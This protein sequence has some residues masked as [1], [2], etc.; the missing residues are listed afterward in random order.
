MIRPP[1]SSTLFPHPPLSR[2]IVMSLKL[3]PLIFNAPA[4]PTL[5]A[6]EPFIVPPVQLN[7]PLTVSVA[8]PA[9]APLMRFTVTE[10]AGSEE[11]TFDLHSHLNIVWLL[12]LTVTE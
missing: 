8:V 11:Y 5:V 4:A 2:S 6:P 1:P 12:L 7:V 10:L 3:V 9:I